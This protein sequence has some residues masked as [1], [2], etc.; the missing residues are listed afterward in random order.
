MEMPFSSQLR[1][2][3][4]DF[5]V[6]QVDCVEAH[7][8]KQAPGIR[9]VRVRGVSGQGQGQGQGL[10]GLGLLGTIRT[11]DQL[12]HGTRRSL[13]RAR[14]TRAARTRRLPAPC[15]CPCTR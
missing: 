11:R 12:E 3:Q 6:H 14:R 9:V 4:P 10:S 15:P 2:F 1:P 5:P 7:G 8:T 13:A